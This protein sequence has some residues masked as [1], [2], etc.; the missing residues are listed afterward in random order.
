MNQEDIKCLLKYN[1][2]TGIFNWA[3]QLNNNVNYGDI[4]GHRNE[5][6]RIVITIDHKNYQ[7]NRLAWLY[8]TGEWPKNEITHINGKNDD[9]RWANLRYA[10]RQEI[11]KNKS[12]Q[13]N[14]KSGIAGVS[15]IKARRIWHVSIRVDKKD[16]YL[17]R[18]K[19]K[20]E[21][22][23]ARKSAENKHGYYERMKNELK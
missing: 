14:N 23:C 12:I 16:R 19:S 6:A 17:G 3:H 10:S 21:A 13:R 7:S 5:F 4:A 8:M 9:N 11:C 20:F 15:W 2:K 22:S 18:F 1:P